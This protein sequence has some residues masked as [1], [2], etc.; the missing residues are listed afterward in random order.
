[1]SPRSVLWF[2]VVCPAQ[3]S[4][5]RELVPSMVLL[6]GFASYEQC[7][8][9]GGHWVTDRRR[10]EGGP[11]RTEFLFKEVVLRS[12]LAI[13]RLTFSLA[14]CQVLP[15]N[16]LVR[17]CRLCVRRSRWSLSDLALCWRAS[18]L[19]D[20][21]PS[22]VLDKVACLGIYFLKGTKTDCRAPGGQGVHFEKR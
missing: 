6:R 10:D 13:P 17:W 19:W 7:D 3:A 5:V 18:S 14:V 12:S 1:M 22:L 9:K 15:T 21:E 20:C 4:C 2:D 8:L 11:G 16:M